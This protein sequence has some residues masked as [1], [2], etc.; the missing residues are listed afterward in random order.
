MT[1]IDSA[2]QA[3]WAGIEHLLAAAG[4]PTADLD[5]S[6][7]R[8]FQ[9]CRRGSGEVCGAVAVERLGAT[10]LLRSLV[11][12]PAVRGSGAGSRLVDAAE[13]QATSDGFTELWLL[14]TDARD[15]FSARGY[16]DRSRDEAPEALRA[17]P[18]FASLCPASA[19]LMSRRLGPV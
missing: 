16:R 2:S 12:A 10:A 5:P 19:T 18:E 7:V 11:V 6:R 8:E 13:R 9:V 17:S 14:T 15:Y 4:L 1:A 3:D